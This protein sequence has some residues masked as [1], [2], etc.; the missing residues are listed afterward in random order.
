[1]GSGLA[2][3]ARR[4]LT[5]SYVYV[6][7][8]LFYFQSYLELLLSKVIDSPILESSS[9][10]PCELIF[11]LLSSSQLVVV[12]VTEKSKVEV[13]Y[14]S[15]TLFPSFITLLTFITYCCLIL[16]LFEAL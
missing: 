9:N 15:L 16:F 6:F 14:Q 2:G 3:L 7:S 10:L 13:S 12:L 11:R 5:T 8:R 4:D 1:M